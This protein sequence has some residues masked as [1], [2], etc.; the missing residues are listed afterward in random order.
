MKNNMMKIFI[1]SSLESNLW[2]SLSFLLHKKISSPLRRRHSVPSLMASRPWRCRGS[3]PPTG[4]RDP[5][6]VLV[7]VSFLVRA[8][9]RRRCP[10]VG[11]MSPTF[12][13]RPDAASSVVGRRVEVCLCQISR[14]S[15]SAGLWWICLDPFFVRLCLGV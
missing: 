1:S 8:V 12:Y 9:C 11:I 15:I 6:L 13:P 3:R 7:R 5:V 2:A 4:G 14:D 10:L